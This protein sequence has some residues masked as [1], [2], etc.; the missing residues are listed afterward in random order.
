[1]F[2]IMAWFLLQ[3]RRAGT[4]GRLPNRTGRA[5]PSRDHAL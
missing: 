1:V 5:V 3:V 2:V 4:E